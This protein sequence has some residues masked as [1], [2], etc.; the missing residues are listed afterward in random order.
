MVGFREDIFELKNQLFLVTPC[1]FLTMLFHVMAV[2]HIE[3]IYFY[4]CKITSGY[5]FLAHA[6]FPGK[7]YVGLSRYIFI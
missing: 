4:F 6:K 3:I 1:V 2:N 5:S 7:A